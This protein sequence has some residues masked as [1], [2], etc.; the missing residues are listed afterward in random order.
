[1]NFIF[2]NINLALS[3]ASMV[4]LL[5][6]YNSTGRARVEYKLNLVLFHTLLGLQKLLIIPVVYRNFDTKF[7]R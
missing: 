3:L 6:P 4:Q 1:M 7:P 2:A 5:L